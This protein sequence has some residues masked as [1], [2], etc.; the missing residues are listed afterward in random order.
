MAY[1]PGTIDLITRELG[2]ALSP[3]K[4]RLIPAQAQPLFAAIGLAYISL[5]ATDAAL[6]DARNAAAALPGLVTDLSTALSGGNAGQIQTKAKALVDGVKNLIAKLKALGAALKVAGVSA[7]DELPVR[8]IKHL[9]LDHLTAGYPGLA[10][11]LGGFDLANLTD[12]G[13]T[14]RTDLKINF[15]GADGFL[16]TV[17]PSSGVESQTELNLDW[18]A[19]AGLRLRGSSNLEIQLPAHIELGIAN[20]VGIYLVPDLKQQGKFGL[21]LSAGLTSKIGPLDATIERAGLKFTLTFA[22]AGD[23]GLAI[24]F[25]PPTGIGL[26]LD[27]GPFVGGGFLS[28]DPE[29]GNYAGVLQIEFSQIIA[30]KAIGILTTRMPNG[31]SGFALLLILTAEFMPPFQL[32]FGFTLSGI[33]GLMGLNRTMNVDR[34]RDGVRNNSLSSVLFPKDPVANALRI[35]SDIREIFPPAEGR[36]VFGPML[37]LGWGTPNLITLEMGLLIEVP[38]PVRVAIIGVLKMLLPDESFRLIGI[39]VNFVGVIDFDRGELSFDASLFDS[40]LL[41]YTLSGDMAVRL[42]WGDDPMFLL[43]VGGFHPAFRPPKNAPSMRRLSISLLGGN[44]RITVE[45]YLAVTSNTVQFGAR[46]EFYV[47]VSEFNVY[48]YLGYDVLFQFNPFYFI[49]QFAAGLAVRVGDDPILS[50]HISGELSGPSPW[51]VRGTGEFTILFI[52]FDVDFDVTFGEKHDTALPPAD[53]MKRL[54]DVLRSK[55]SWQANLPAG[56]NLLVSTRD[57]TKDTA[58]MLVH[59]FGTLTI[60]QQDVPLSLQLDRFGSTKPDKPSKFEITAITMGPLGSDIPIDAVETREQ[61]APALYQTMTDAQR[62]SSPSFVRMRG[63][64]KTVTSKFLKFM[65][66]VTRKVEYEVSIIDKQA[67]RW[68]LKDLIWKKLL[69]DHFDVLVRGS[70]TARSALSPNAQSISPLAPPKFS[71]AQ[72]GYAVVKNRDLKLVHDTA[73]AASHTE[74]LGL[75]KEMI[76]AQ[77]ELAG[78][79]Q[80]VPLF[81]VQ[82]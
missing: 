65:N 19:P 78:S 15:P 64:A 56:L 60:T 18:S 39:Q 42:S 25:N 24:G 70:A 20:I 77:P 35:I 43:S 41:I 7:A 32:G 48:G 81:E 6:Q 82:R 2:R 21:E 1:P 4:D 47:G 55:D 34:L 59:P 75:L 69:V 63:G 67:K 45:T 17:L 11:E 13:V 52:D 46:A 68:P 29:N 44:P 28:F 62:L 12:T 76:A 37:K 79:V 3:L 16:Q 23:L 49:A 71:L 53:V 9:L 27:S 10:N 14:L 38:S 57:L 66:P 80:V 73:Q 30:I 36:F 31:A 40:R 8:L 54:M 5:P 26:A 51:H 61:F 74:A 33:G 72:E 58:E 50:I 22:N